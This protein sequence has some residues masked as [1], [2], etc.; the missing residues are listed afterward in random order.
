MLNCFCNHCDNINIA[1]ISRT[2]GTIETTQMT[3][4]FMYSFLL[5]FT[6][7][8]SLF[9]CLSLLSLIDL[10]FINIEHTICKRKSCKKFIF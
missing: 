9:L 10:S 4:K 8:V 2:V 7:E 3:L 5:V 1:P 6:N